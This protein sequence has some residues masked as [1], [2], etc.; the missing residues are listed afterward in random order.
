[1]L[2]RAAVRPALAEV[3]A[4]AAEVSRPPLVLVALSGGADSLALAAAVA[5]EA[6]AAGVRAGAVVIDHDLQQGSAT[7]ATRAAEQARALGLDPVEVRRVE[8]SAQ[9]ASVTGGM[10]AA[11]RSA[12]YAAFEAAASELGAAGLLTAHTRDD[13]AEQVLLALARGSGTR[14]LA[15]I[16]VRRSLDGGLLMLRPLLQEGVG[17]TRDLTEASCAELGLEPW[18]DPHNT[19]L[20]FARVRA[21]HRV[22]PLLEAELGPGVAAALAR[23]ADQAREDAVALDELADEWLRGIL[24][25]ETREAEAKLPAEALAALPAALRNRVIRRLAMQRFGSHLSREHTL[26]IASLVTNWRGQG[27]IH[28]PRINVSRADGSVVFRAR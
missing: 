8:V 3:V 16:P 22:M 13:Q 18:R 10:E 6:P 25:H 24:D 15:G 27:P 5:A 28:V 11:A 4:H 26:A 9:P 2:V 12:R 21:R 17:V 19:D 1:M 14:S 23:S 7:V 20:S